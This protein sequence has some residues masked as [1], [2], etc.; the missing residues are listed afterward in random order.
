MA[1]SLCGDTLR[2]DIQ[3]HSLRLHLL[4]KAPTLAFPMLLPLREFLDFLGLRMSKD[5]H[6]TFHRSIRM[7]I[8]PIPISSALDARKQHQQGLW[9][10]SRPHALWCF[11]CRQRSIYKRE[12]RR[13]SGPSCQRCPFKSLGNFGAVTSRKLVC[14]APFNLQ[15]PRCVTSNPAAAAGTHAVTSTQKCKCNTLNAGAGSG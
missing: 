11:P 15:H 7:R 3:G 10:P 2:I 1:G 5:R 9:R 6:P 8:P 14:D 13:R 4:M 12:T